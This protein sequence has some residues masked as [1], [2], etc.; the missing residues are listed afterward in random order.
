MLGILGTKM[1]VTNVWT[2]DVVYTVAGMSCTVTMNDNGQWTAALSMQ[3]H[4]Q[5]Q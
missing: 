3:T 4:I 2:V 5:Y 1:T